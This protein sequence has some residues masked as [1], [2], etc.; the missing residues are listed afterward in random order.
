MPSPSQWLYVQAPNVDAYVGKELVS[1]S[2]LNVA[3]TVN[4]S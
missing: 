2:L 3:L 1:L 4:A